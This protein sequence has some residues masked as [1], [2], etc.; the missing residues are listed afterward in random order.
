FE[1]S[2]IQRCAA[3]G[4]SIPVSSQASSRSRGSITGVRSWM[5]ASSPSASRVMIVTESRKR[6]SSLAAGLSCS[7]GPLPPGDQGRHE[8]RRAV[9]GGDEA[10]LLAGAA[11][12]QPLVVAVH[13]DDRSSATQAAPEAGL[14]GKRL[15]PGVEGARGEALVLRERRQQT[16][17][18]DAQGP[19]RAP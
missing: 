10:G 2:R 18:G 7:P 14:V 4:S 15:A 5:S 13:R 12:A 6:P 9:G 11:V 19:Q 16:P 3:W 8:Q 1:S 17:A